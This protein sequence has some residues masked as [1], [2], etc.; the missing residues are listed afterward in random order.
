M[1]LVANPG[2]LD[3]VEQ[4]IDPDIILWTTH[5]FCKQ[6]TNGREV[7]WHQDRHYW[8]IRPLA[9]CTAWAAMDDS[10]IDNGTLRCIPGSYAMGIFEH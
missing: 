7:P 1:D 10:A 2:I 5:L 4:L 8:P 9:T 6:P 3:M